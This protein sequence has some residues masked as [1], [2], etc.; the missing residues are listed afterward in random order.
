[1]I[2]DGV[3]YK[4]V[5]KKEDFKAIENH[6]FYK[7][8]MFCKKFVIPKQKLDIEDINSLL[9]ESKITSCKMIETPMGKKVVIN[10][11]IFIKILYTAKNA[12]QSVHT[13]H[14]KIPFCT[15]LT[16]FS[17]EEN[18][19]KIDLCKKIHSFIEYVQVNKISQQRVEI[20]ILLLVTI[21]LEDFLNTYKTCLQ[22]NDIDENMT[23]RNKPL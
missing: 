23:Y 9:I 3:S 22:C 18:D 13:V 17:M 2:N 11:L 21:E 6:H 5:L 16:C 15:F 8:L 12:T 19:A 14:F 4:G 7:Q 20:Q 10:G 1:M